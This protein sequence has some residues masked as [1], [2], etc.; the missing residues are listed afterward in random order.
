[1]IFA[2]YDDAGEEFVGWG[3]TVEEAYYKLTEMISVD[4]PTEILFYEAKSINVK[5]K[6]DITFA[7]L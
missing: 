1:M 3:D 2:I 7:V 6:M 4:R 5:V